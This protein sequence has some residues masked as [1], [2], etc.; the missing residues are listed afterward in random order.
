MSKALPGEHYCKKH[1]GN[2]SHYAEH[3]CTVCK[4]EGKSKWNSPSNF[5]FH[6]NPVIGKSD[7]RVGTYHIV[8]YNNLMNDWVDFESGKVT[9]T[10]TG[11]M[12]IEE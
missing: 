11:W 9:G 10:L 8:Y 7:N 12:E 6:D 3:N 4:L 2:H 1:Q 5:P